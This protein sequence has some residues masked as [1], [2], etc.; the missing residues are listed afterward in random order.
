MHIH[1]LVLARYGGCPG[2]PDPERVFAMLGRVRSYEFYEGVTDVFALAAIYW[3]S[4]A[5]GHAF[6]DGNK[7][8]AVAVSLLFLHRNA[9]AAFS[10]PELE[11]V[12]VEVASGQKTAADLA[13]FLR[14][15]Y[16]N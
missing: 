15:A 16:A 3:V 14:S 12:A 13:D 1:D 8:T 4:I 9:V 11:S 7:R 10:R 5:R 2:C 6:A